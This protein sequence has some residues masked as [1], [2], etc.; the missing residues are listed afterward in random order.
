MNAK[1][2]FLIEK[3]DS[4]YVICYVDGNTPRTVKIATVR[5]GMSIVYGPSVIAFLTS[6]HPIDLWQRK[7]GIL[8]V[9]QY[10]AAVRLWNGDTEGM[11]PF[12]F[13]TL[14]GVVN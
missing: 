10:N 8:D 5:D 11:V 1:R 2:P 4:D 6:P 7:P 13:F 3:R 14:N 12:D 9:P